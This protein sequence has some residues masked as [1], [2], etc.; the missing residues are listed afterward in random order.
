MGYVLFN[1]VLSVAMLVAFISGVL[2]LT[3]FFVTGLT[4]RS[5]KRTQAA[6]GDDPQNPED[7]FIGKTAHSWKRIRKRA[8]I[9][10]L[11]FGL[12]GLCLLSRS[13]PA[14]PL[15]HP[16][17]TTIGQLCGEL[18]ALAEKTPTSLTYAESIGAPE[19]LVVT[20][21]D[22]AVAR[23]ALRILL[24]ARV[25][26]LGCQLD[27]CQLRYEDYRFVFGE[28]TFTL[29]FV[30][31]SY[32]CYGGQYYELGENRMDRLRDLLHGMAADAQMSAPQSKWYGEGAVLRTRFVDNGDEAR[33]VTELTLSAGAECVSGFIE[34]AY[35]VLS[36]DRQPDGYVLRYTYGDFYSHEAIRT[37]RVTV[38]NGRMV[39]T[40]IAQ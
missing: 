24:S 35:D 10:T 39:I 13:R 28:D 26:R 2:F 34:G 15:P 11:I 4:G 29:S 27:M 16:A 7:R 17:M 14:Q 9:L 37:C 20:V 25:S 21:D 3:S 33:S 12:P 31:A 23:E 8:L 30:P 1:I 22:P 38:V 6:V 36:A 19:T 32:F 40:D 18:S 5:Q